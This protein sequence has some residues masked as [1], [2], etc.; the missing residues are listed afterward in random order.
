MWYKQAW[1]EIQTM[2]A[3]PLS[4]W[5]KLTINKRL[6]LII[7]WKFISDSVLSHH[8][9]RLAQIPQQ[10]AILAAKKTLHKVYR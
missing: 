5:L 3:C 6:L 10:A 4:F 1:Q 2:K 9:S 8:P 7:A